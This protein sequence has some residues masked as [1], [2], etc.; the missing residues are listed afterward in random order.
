MDGNSCDL[1]NPLT[2]P[3]YVAVFI[4][5]TLVFIFVSRRLVYP[6]GQGSLWGILR[7]EGMHAVSKSLLLS[8]QLYYGYAAFLI[9]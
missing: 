2:L 1:W 5:D 4:H 6:A 3:Y 9:S 8:G 7:G